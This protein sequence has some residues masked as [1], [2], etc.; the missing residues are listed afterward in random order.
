MTNYRSFI[1]SKLAAVDERR[2]ELERERSR[3]A[4]AISVLDEADA[5]AGHAAPL[6]EDHTS[7]PI[8]TNSGSLSD[9]I[10][11]CLTKSNQ[12]MTQADIYNCVSRGMTV[13]RTNMY[14][15]MYRMK[16][17]DR[18]Y[19]AGMLWGL[20]ERKSSLQ[21]V[22]TTSHQERQMPFHS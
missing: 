7:T 16:K 19:K 11:E 14:S 22:A 8:S 4:A 12:M 1:E 2:A 17:R 15:C 3:L 5:S 18:I 21:G 10:I 20:T 13:K 9:A 6:E